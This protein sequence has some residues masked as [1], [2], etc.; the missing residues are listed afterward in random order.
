MLKIKK[1]FSLLIPVITLAVLVVFMAGCEN[2]QEAKEEEYKAYAHREIDE[3]Y[4]KGNLDVLDEHYAADFIYHIPPQPDIEGLEAYKEF[5]AG[6]R[7]GYPD[8][9]IT[10]DD[11]I[12]EGDKVVTR[13]TYQGTHTGQ[14]PTLGIP[15]TGKKVI[16]T[17][18]S[19]THWRDG[20]IVETWN[21]VDYLGLMQQLGFNIVPPQEQGGK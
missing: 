5:I 11:I 14:S 3:A 2:R 18:C 12:T 13:W 1:N 16:F 17:G 21:Y 9:Q 15:P 4:N 8:I 10:I 6:N 20:K 7:I 19:V